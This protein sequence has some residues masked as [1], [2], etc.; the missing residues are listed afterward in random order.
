MKEYD[1][2]VAIV[3][4]GLSAQLT[5]LSLHQQHPAVHIVM[6]EQHEPR[7]LKGLAYS[8]A[9]P[10]QPLN[11]TAAKMSLFVQHDTHF[12]EWLYDHYQ[13]Q[14]TIA[15]LS[16]SFQPRNVY[17]QYCRQTL[18]AHIPNLTII[19]QAVTNISHTPQAKVLSLASGE[20][21]NAHFVVLATGNADAPPLRGAAQYKGTVINQLAGLSLDALQHY[22]HILI[23]GSGLTAVDILCSLYQANYRGSI[24]VTSRKGLFPLAHKAHPNA[25]TAVDVSDVLHCPPTL[26][27]Y[28]TT[29]R[30][31]L[32]THPNTDWR[33]YIDALR[34]H[35]PALWSKLSTADRKTFF[36]RLKSQWEVHRHRMPQLSAS[37]ISSLIEAG[38]LRLEQGELTHS[39]ANSVTLS[40]GAVLHPDCIVNCTGQV[41]DISQ[42]S[43][44]YRH[45][46]A[47]QVVMPDELRLGIE[48]SEMGEIVTPNHATDSRLFAVGSLWRAKDYEAIAAR[49]LRIQAQTV[50][51]AIH[52][53]TLALHLSDM[54]DYNDFAAAAFSYPPSFYTAMLPA[55]VF[56]PNEYTRVLLY[57]EQYTVL[58]LVWSPQ[59]KT[60]IHD[61]A[62]ASATVKVLQGCVTER[63]YQRDSKFCCGDEKTHHVGSIFRETPADIHAIENKTADYAITLHIY[64][65]SKANLDGVCIFDDNENKVG[66][67]NERAKSSS[68]LEPA[69]SF[70]SIGQIESV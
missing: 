59:V 6:F 22:Q 37:I 56:R 47:Q 23:V 13:Q 34:P 4:S 52:Q 70:H 61:H 51:R 50:A 19:Q 66:L 40:N 31:Y 44:L 48:L 36:A 14:Y 43:E 39:T 17:A 12:T 57:K 29:I 64:N 15:E 33:D 5:A 18:Q 20:T 38:T 42:Q 27:H 65:Q 63:K 21:F 8:S 60:S 3:G 26:Y 62:N 54:G 69:T 11:V 9:L 41:T 67:L 10:Y 7:T 30:Q 1:C 49:E 16:E 24:T 68:W 58:A 46:V 32:K 53:R 35:L 45:L 28:F 25:V 2:T 55:D